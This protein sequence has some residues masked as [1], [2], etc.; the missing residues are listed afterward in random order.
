MLSV[1]PTWG[2]S[3]GMGHGEWGCGLE[4]RGL[5]VLGVHT[6]NLKT[7]K[8]ELG[9][10]AQGVDLAWGIFGT[11]DTGASHHTFCPAAVWLFRLG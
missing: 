7:L 2:M 10:F 8:R 1:R 11:S 5:G 6:L 9:M 3:R 4:V